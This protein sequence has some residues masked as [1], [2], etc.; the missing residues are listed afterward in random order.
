MNDN[1]GFKKRLISKFATIIISIN[2][3]NIFSLKG[4]LSSTSHLLLFS[5]WGWPNWDSS[6]NNWHDVMQQK[7]VTRSVGKWGY[8]TKMVDIW[9]KG[10]YC[11]EEY[12]PFE[13]QFCC[14]LNYCSFS[15]IKSE[16][17]SEHVYLWEYPVCVIYERRSFKA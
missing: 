4:L 5:K 17:R 10:W 2:L 7:L 8:A 14:Y 13:W 16:C 6:H 11:L 12:C 1:K 9:S 3:N 15:K